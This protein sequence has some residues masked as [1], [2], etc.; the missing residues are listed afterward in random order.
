MKKKYILFAIIA[1]VLVLASCS[2]FIEDLNRPSGFIKISG[3]TYDG[4]TVLS[5][6][7]Q[8]FILG[9]KVSIPDLYVCPHEVTQREY[10]TYC[11]YHDIAI[12]NTYINRPNGNYGVGQNHP[13]Y[14]VSWFDALIYCNY[15]SI[16]EG[17]TPCYKIRGKTNPDEWGNIPSSDSSSVT[18]SIWNAAECDF[19]ANGYRLPTE[20]E[21]EYLARGGNE[22][23]FIYSGSDTLNDVAWNWTNSAVLNPS[24]LKSHEVMTKTP[25]SLGLYDM[26]GNVQ[27]WCWD[28]HDTITYGTPSTGPASGTQRV[29]RGGYYNGSIEDPYQVNWHGVK[30]L[31]KTRTNGR[32]F[33]V[34]CTAN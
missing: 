2:T 21:W 34:V 25:N 20:A 13:T 24:D 32:G 19:S 16:A 9:R 22:D 26:S 27:E 4:S 3:T 7:S 28:W 5:P 15:R 29:V 6:E 14:Y 23:S 8:V 12:P 17:R 1:F 11:T 31:P 18:S 30:D 33:R 10:E